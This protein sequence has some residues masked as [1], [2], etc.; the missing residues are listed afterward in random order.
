MLHLRAG[1]KDP[2]EVVKDIKVMSNCLTR[3]D[4]VLWLPGFSLLQWSCFYC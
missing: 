2:K 4:F 3:F 1:L